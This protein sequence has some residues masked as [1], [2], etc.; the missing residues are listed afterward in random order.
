MKTYSFKDSSGAFTH[1][2]A[3]AFLFAGQ[4]GMNQMQIA[5]ATEKTAHDVASDGAVMVSFISGDNGS[6]AI[7]VQQTSDFH[8]FMLAWYNLIKAAADS[9]DVSSWASA[10]I[11]IRNGVDGSVHVAT[12]VSP[13][14]I[15]DKVYTA[16]GQRITWNLMAADIQNVTLSL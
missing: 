14:K 6:V 10:A 2:L 5:M 7:E 16:Q 1:P 4:K 11:T 8:T 3:G 12:G 15:P 9:G 13:S